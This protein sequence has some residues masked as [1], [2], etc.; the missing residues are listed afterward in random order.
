M[1]ILSKCTGE[2]APT[3]RLLYTRQK[4]R[5]FRKIIIIFAEHNLL[6]KKVC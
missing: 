5:S 6:N 4:K 1:D 3:T 2:T